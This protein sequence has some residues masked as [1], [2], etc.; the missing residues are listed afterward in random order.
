MRGSGGRGDTSVGGAAAAIPSI[1]G[2]E[3]RQAPSHVSLFFRSSILFVQL[4]TAYVAV[5]IAGTCAQEQDSS[6]LMR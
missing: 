2:P 3:T 6:C 5:A 1:L 4:Q